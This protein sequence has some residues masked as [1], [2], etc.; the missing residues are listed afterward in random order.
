[1]IDTPPGDRFINREL[2]WLEFN[3]RVLEL[4]RGSDTPVLERAKFLA[5]FAGNLDEFYMVRVA[6][7]K[8]QFAAGLSSRS[9]DG[10]M[11][12][13][14]LE[15]VSVK[16]SSLALA[17]AHLFLEE[18]LPDLS[19]SGIAIC[20]WED[21]DDQQ[22]KELDEYFMDQIFPVVTPLA[23]GPGH[24]F[25]YISSRSLNLAVLVR[26]PGG[27]SLHFARVKVPP[28]LPRFV[29]TS[30]GKVFVPIEDVIAANLEEL[31]PGMEIVE[32]HAFRV[33][34]NGDLEMNDDGAE[35]LLQALE[36]ELRKSRFTPA[37][38]LEIHADMPPAV[39][40]L[41]QRELEIGEQDVHRLP[42]P[43]DLSGL[44]NLYALDRIDLKDPVFQPVTPASLSLAEDAPHD[45]F[46]VLRSDDVLVQHPY[47]SFATTVER[48]I[49]EAAMD[50]AVLAI[51]QT[52]YRT[53]G[54]SPIVDA[55][56]AAA[57]RGKQVVV[58]VEIT[59]RFDELANI[60]WARTLEQAGCHVVYGLVGVK[61]HCKLCLVVRQEANGL[62]RYI[63]IGTGNYNPITAR[64]YEDLGLLTSDPELGAD[65]SELF[66]F[67][68]GY[69][70]QT[71]YRSLV[72]APHELRAR[73]VKMI[74]RESQVSEA[75]SPGRIIF[76]LNSLADEEVIDALYEAS[77]R[78]VQ[79]DVIVRGICVLR[80]QVEGLSD[81][82]RVRS[83]VGRFLEHSRIYYFGNGG[84]EEFFI[85]SADI[86]HRNL[87]RRIETLVATRSPEINSRLKGILELALADNA[88][89]WELGSDARWKK[90]SPG[91]SEPPIELQKELMSRAG[92]DA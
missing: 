26:D 91:R 55:L 46:S 2:S 61:T 14:Q 78:S 35:D 63:H 23:V 33:T 12:G 64:L 34:R 54:E 25:P 47:D 15:A 38:R 16:A 75:G 85:G 72:V 24:P 74:E 59:A 67:L 39:L 62:R 86:M 29:A 45:I 71:S 90:I 20:G 42:G 31:C 50:P 49:S 5:I 3:D 81:N 83:I 89:A 11:P 70:R 6:G 58:L 88:S 27:G 21:L 13:Q 9:S 92:K 17:H 66:N 76:K 48:F 65:V 87:D 8:R 82:I 1:M 22:R 28:L 40:D 10:L 80:P 41:L 84:S 73:I 36:E 56:I 77:Q 68:T 37:V 79:I 52:L 18:V 30:D 32:H 4:A 7:L 53:S 43:L 60:G 19:R 69:S 44:W 57:E 51:K